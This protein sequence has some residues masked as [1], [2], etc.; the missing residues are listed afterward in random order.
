MN[1]QGFNHAGFVLRAEFGLGD[2]MT[3]VVRYVF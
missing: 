3:G 1:F 2:K